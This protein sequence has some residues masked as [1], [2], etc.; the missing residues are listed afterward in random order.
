M[1]R[2]IFGIMAAI[3]AIGSFAFTMPAKGKHLTTKLFNYTGPDYKQTNVQNPANWTYISA[4]NSACNSTNTRACQI[5][6]N[7]SLVNPDNTLK[8]TV[9]IPTQSSST[10]VYFVNAGSDVTSRINK[11]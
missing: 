3:I 7:T 1:K 9:T 11:N 10:D 2:T 8:S 5:E 6:V 4:P